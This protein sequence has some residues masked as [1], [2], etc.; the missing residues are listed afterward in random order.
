MRLFLMLSLLQFGCVIHRALSRDDVMREIG[1]RF[2]LEA[3][4]SLFYAR[5]QNP[6]VRFAGDQLEVHLEAEAGAPGFLRRGQV[7]VVGSVDYRGSGIYLKDAAVKEID[8]GLELPKEW[9]PAVEQAVETA[10]LAALAEKPLYE[11]SDHRVKKVWV[12]G[13]KLMLEIRP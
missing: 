11:I 10:L 9:K 3:R 6:D 2:P 8:L 7:L 12:A 4:R 1:P 13:D 5:L